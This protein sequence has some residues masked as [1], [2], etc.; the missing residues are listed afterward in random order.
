MM[1]II[2]LVTGGE[3][4]VIA[5]FCVAAIGVVG[6]VGAAMVSVIDS[7]NHPFN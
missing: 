2:S 4:P 7:F 1:Q 3:L 6:I 5:L